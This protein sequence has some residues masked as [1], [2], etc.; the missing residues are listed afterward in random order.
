MNPTTGMNLDRAVTLAARLGASV[1]H[2]HRTGEL[3]LPSDLL[4]RPCRVNGHSREA[5]RHLTRWLK[6][7]QAASCNGAA[8]REHQKTPITHQRGGMSE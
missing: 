8:A 6:K 4:D 1:E 7:L 3:R 2:V 5:S